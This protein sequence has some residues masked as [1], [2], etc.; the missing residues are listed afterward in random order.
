M[1]RTGKS[2]RCDHEKSGRGGGMGTPEN[3]GQIA[4]KL[5]GLAI[6]YGCQKKIMRKKQLGMEFLVLLVRYI[7]EYRGYVNWTYRDSHL[8]SNKRRVL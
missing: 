5:R 3:T 2:E 7:S 6:A 4:P 1:V 8:T